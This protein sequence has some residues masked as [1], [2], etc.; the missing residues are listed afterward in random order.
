M[1]KEYANN[2]RKASKVIFD[3]VPEMNPS[4][5]GWGRVYVEIEKPIPMKWRSDF[6]QEL[7]DENWLYRNALEKSIRYFG[8]RWELNE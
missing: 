2:L 7:S 1:T 4:Y 6:Y 5:P 8:V 3:S